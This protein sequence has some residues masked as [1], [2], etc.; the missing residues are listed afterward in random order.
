[1]S[2]DE[3]EQEVAGYYSFIANKIKDAEVNIKQI[4]DPELVTETKALVKKALDA[5]TN[6]M[7]GY[8]RLEL[9]VNEGYEDD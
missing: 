9:V 5:L 4:K 1:M 6:V 7:A 2:R 3:Y 8:D